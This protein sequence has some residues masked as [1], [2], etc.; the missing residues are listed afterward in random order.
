MNDNIL[1]AIIGG[2]FTLS[3]AIL[4]WL[5]S[6]RP[7][8]IVGDPGIQRESAIAVR[9][10]W[11]GIVVQ[12]NYPGSPLKTDIV[13]ELDFKRDTIMGSARIVTHF[14]PER[15]GRAGPVEI[16]LRLRGGF[17]TD[18]LLKL[19]YKD[20]TPAVLQFGTMVLELSPRADEL[21]GE[22][23]G[24]GSLSKRVI[25]GMVKLVKTTLSG[26]ASPAQMLQARPTY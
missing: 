23:V 14:E 10:F 9:G 25:H 18:R 26:A 15:H 17:Y 4:T 13:M 6:R 21:E 1:P 7:S 22:L 20:Q 24:Y 11:Q 5:L 16:Q 19:E 2:L 3:A 12:P 8:E